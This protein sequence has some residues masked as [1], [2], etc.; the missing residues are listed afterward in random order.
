M[1][2]IWLFLCNQ[3][4]AEATDSADADATTVDEAGDADAVDDD[5]SSAQQDAE[6]S[7]QAVYSRLTN[8]ALNE[9]LNSFLQYRVGQKN[10]PLLLSISSPIILSLAHSADS[11]R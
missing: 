11:L 1:T 8:T 3:V 4:M 6:R 9:V 7:L 5:D 2:N 10:M